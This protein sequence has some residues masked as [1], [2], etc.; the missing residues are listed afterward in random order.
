MMRKCL[1]LLLCALMLLSFPGAAEDTCPLLDC[2]DFFPLDKPLHLTAWVVNALS[3]ISVSDSYVLDWIWEKSHIDLEITREF[4]GANAKAALTLA[5]S[6]EDALP[7][8]LL[9]T[10][11]TKAECALYGIQGLVIPLDEYLSECENW[12]RLNEICGP[13]HQADLEMPD[14]HIYCYGSVNECFHL[15][16][17]AR[18][19]VYRDWIDSLCGGKLPETTEEFR[20]YLRKVATEDPNGNGLPDEIPLT[21]QIQDGW[22]T[23]PFTFLSNSFVHNNTIYGST[24]QTVAAGCYLQNGQVLC[25]WT[26]EGYREAL[27]YMHSL[28][29]EGLLHSQVFTQNAFQLTARLESDPP[30]VGAVAS[31]SLPTYLKQNREDGEETDWIC[32]PP[33]AGPDGTRMSYISAYDYFY[34]CNGLVTKVCAHPREA[35]QLFDL[36]ASAEGTMVQNYGREG[37]NWFWCEENEGFGIDGVPALYR[38]DYQS[39]SESGD[40]PVIWPSDVQ[41]SST[42]DAFRKGLLVDEN[43]FNGEKLLWECAQAYDAYSPGAETVYPNV[44]FTEEQSRALLQYESTI[45]S[46]VSNSLIH[47]VIGSMDLDRDWEACLSMLDILGQQAYQQLLQDAYDSYS[48][49]Q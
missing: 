31:G 41:I 27:K 20:E 4:T 26:E 23:D 46:Y 39:Q 42:F 7:D 16:H 1:A 13:A 10:R 6:N 25:N 18:M 33:L 36:M 34:N 14:G 28:Y 30:L 21:G 22:A 3:S 40:R 44:A 9:C 29:A 11:W 35:V 24:N 5:L 49:Y 47:F 2:G 38:Y 8:I 19:W 45:G 17:Q 37:Y 15:T 43:T 48:Q 12:N 32:L